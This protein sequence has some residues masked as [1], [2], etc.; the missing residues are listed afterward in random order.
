M[1]NQVLGSPLPQLP[2]F[3]TMPQNQ[4]LPFLGINQP[5]I[6]PQMRAQPMVLMDPGIQQQPMM[7][8]QG[9][10]PPIAPTLPFMQPQASSLPQM[11]PGVGLSGIQGGPLMG[12]GYPSPAVMQGGIPS[13][14]SFPGNVSPTQGKEKS[15]LRGQVD[16]E[17]LPDWKKD[18]L[19]K[20][21]KSQLDVQD[22]L[23]QQILE[24]KAEKERLEKQMK[25]EENRENQRIMKEQE[26][27][28]LRYAKEAEDARK[29][30]E[31]A[32]IA[33]QKIKAERLQKKQADQAALD[34]AE[35]KVKENTSKQASQSRLAYPP[36]VSP[37]G[38]LPPA[39]VSPFRSA[40]PPIPTLRKKMVEAEAESQVSA[41][42]PLGT[43]TRKAETAYAGLSPSESRPEKSTKP[44]AGTLRGSK[45]LAASGPQKKLMPINDTEAILQQLSALKMNLDHEQSKVRTE[46][47]QSP[48]YFAEHYRDSQTT[49]PIASRLAGSFPPDSAMQS[50]RAGP[51]ISDLGIS[52]KPL[53]ER[54]RAYLDYQ[55]RELALLQSKSPVAVYATA[56]DVPAF[57]RVSKQDDVV[58]ESFMQQ[59]RSRLGADAESE[60]ISTTA[61]RQEIER[62]SAVVLNGAHQLAP[63][64][65]TYYS[66]LERSLAR[67]S[68]STAANTGDVDILSTI[69][70]STRKPQE[71]PPSSASSFDL[72][73]LQKLN[74]MRFKRL[75][76][77][78]EEPSRGRCEDDDIISA[79][80]RREKELSGNQERMDRPLSQ[81]ESKFQNLIVGRAGTG[82]Y[83]K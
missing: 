42:A 27:L 44:I 30:M 61:L 82:I 41:S 29:A 50:P 23:R 39:S 45:P 32:A 19:A 46:L 18:E 73:A 20:K 14:P 80:L 4:Q 10:L 3:G 8:Y 11:L 36:S 57:S 75:T 38:L 13:A 43:D 1:P 24:K 51:A 52:S 79:F 16:I 35:A 26:E 63:T 21:Q 78:D 56:M 40:S 2:Q 64:S 81:T 62:K 69:G 7:G 54:Q 25:M 28:R 60:A 53:H 71:R 66:D 31:E 59:Q 67:Q 15:F 6:A 33:N 68:N 37:V 17:A 72:E 70:A 55:E 22:A 12:M 9:I 34:D 58:L 48:K 5:L 77:A 65:S 74:E 47:S 83:P 76:S 49:N